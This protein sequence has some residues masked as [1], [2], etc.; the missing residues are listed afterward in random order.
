[1]YKEGEVMKLSWKLL[2]LLSGLCVF[3]SVMAQDAYQLSAWQ[4]FKAALKIGTHG[5]GAEE[6]AEYERRKE[7]AK[8]TMTAEQYAAQKKDLKGGLIEQTHGWYSEIKQQ[9]EVEKAKVKQEKEAAKVKE[10]QEKEAA[11]VREKTAKELEKKSESLDKKINDLQKKSKTGQL[12]A[13]EKATL[14]TSMQERARI[15]DAR[16]EANPEEF[17]KMRNVLTE[18]IEAL[19]AGIATMEEKGLNAS[20]MLAEKRKK[21]E[22]LKDQINQTMTLQQKREEAYKNAEMSTQDR[23]K[24][25]IAAAQKHGESPAQIAK[26][27]EELAAYEQFLKNQADSVFK[28]KY[29]I[30]QLPPTQQ[31][32]AA[33][34]IKEKQATAG[35]GTARPSLEDIGHRPAEEYVT[36]PAAQSSAQT[37]TQ[38]PTLADIGHK[39]AD[40]YI[41][42]PTKQELEQKQQTA[43]QPSTW[44]ASQKPSGKQTDTFIGQQRTTTPSTWKPAEKPSSKPAGTFVGQQRVT[45]PYKSFDDPG[46]REAVI[47]AQERVSRGVQE[48]AKFQ[49]PVAEP[50]AQPAAPVEQRPAQS[51]VPPP[52]MDDPGARDIQYQEKL[53]EILRSK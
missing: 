12:T 35:A 14:S 19:K 2:A 4:K 45:T 16:I 52:Q 3:S 32:Q 42:L 46:A 51:L 33:A 38:R 30:T 39:T 36:L 6:Y 31:E 47:A 10:K 37:E 7:A 8:A 41:H 15:Q 17:K 53:R 1:M 48:Q 13:A 28:Q 18:K 50:A 34:F 23:I 29:G 24:N 5:M 25:E 26:R 49:R 43:E 11:K 40:D 27:K 22:D 21:L 20:P 9:R 44:K